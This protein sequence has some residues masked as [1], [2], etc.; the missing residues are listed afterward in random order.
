MSSKK[1]LD[2][3]NSWIPTFLSW[4]MDSSVSAIL[5]TPQSP[6]CPSR[7]GSCWW[8]LTPRCL[9]GCDRS[10]SWRPVQ[11]KIIKICSYLMKSTWR[12][13]YEILP[14]WFQ[15]KELKASWY[16]CL[17]SSYKILCLMYLTYVEAV[18]WSPMFMLVVTPALVSGYW[19][20]LV[21]GGGRGVMCAATAAS[22]GAMTHR[23]SQPQ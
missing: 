17:L 13:L 1:Q 8:C 18:T 23:R 5:S 16:S 21:A 15:S 2:N 14:L 12:L 19:Q 9:W 22:S 11:E 20:P 3:L 4:H 7:C 10:A 6:D